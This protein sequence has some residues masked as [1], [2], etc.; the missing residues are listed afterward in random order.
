VGILAFWLL[1]SGYIAYFS[2]MKWP[3]FYFLSKIL[4]HHHVPWPRYP[5]RRENFGD[6]HTF[7]ADMILLIFA[8]IFMTSWPKWGLCGAKWGNG[9]CDVF[10][11]YFWGFLHLCQFWW[12]SIKNATMRLRKLVYNLFHAICYSYGQII[13][14]NNLNI[15]NYNLFSELSENKFVRGTSC[16][17]Q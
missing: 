8:W 11:F 14:P 13:S 16:L 5:Q 6:S 10:H 2:C 15:I 3:Y 4:C 1:N 7:K 12:K 17:R 9:W